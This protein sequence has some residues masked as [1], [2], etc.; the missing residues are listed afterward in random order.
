L[1][2]QGKTQQEIGSVLGFSQPTITKYVKEL[3]AHG[4][5][6]VKNTGITPQLLNLGLITQTEINQRRKLSKKRE[7]YVSE[8]T[9]LVRRYLESLPKSDRNAKITKYFKS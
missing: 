2:K 9:M 7:D 4:F 1:K 5:L 3:T 6:T 8:E